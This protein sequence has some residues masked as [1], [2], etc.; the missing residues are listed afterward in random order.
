[1]LVASCAPGSTVPETRPADEVA[2]V[3]PI[4]GHLVRLEL[5]RNTTIRAATHREYELASTG[6]ISERASTAEVDCYY[7]GRPYRLDD[8]PSAA[9]DVVALSLC[10]GQIR[11][12]VMLDRTPWAIEPASAPAEVLVSRL[13]QPTSEATRATVTVEAIEPGFG[14][15][16]QGLVTPTKFLELVLYSDQQR[17]Q[18]LGSAVAT[19]AI[20]VANIADALYRNG[21]LTPAIG[22]V[23][24]AQIMFSRGNPFVV[25]D[26][27]STRVSNFRTWRTSRNDLPTGDAHFM[28]NGLGFTASASLG[29]AYTGGACNALTNFGFALTTTTT[30][31]ALEGTA[32][33]HELGHSLGMQ[34][35]GAG[36]ACATSGFIMSAGANSS[37]PY[38]HW[39]TCSQS[40]LTSFLAAQTCLDNS[41]TAGSVD[42]CG[43]GVVSGAEQ[44]DCG[45]DSCATVDPCCD[46][47]TCRYGDTDADGTPDCSDGCPSDPAKTAAGACGCGVAD[48]DADGDGTANCHDSCP[49]DPSKTSDADTDHDG[50]ANCVDGCPMDPAKRA[51]GTCGCGVADADADADG[52]ADCLDGC[53]NDASKTAPGTCGCGVS[54]CGDDDEDSDDEGSND[55]SGSGDG[56]GDPGSGGCASTGGGELGIA[57]LLVVVLRRRM[58]ALPRRRSVGPR[59][60]RWSPLIVLLVMIAVLATACGPSG[61]SQSGNCSNGDCSD[62][63]D[64]ST[65]GP[66]AN[67]PDVTFIGMPTTPSISLVLDRGSSMFSNNLGTVTRYAA[68]RDVF[69][70]TGGVVTQMDAEAYFGASVYTCSDGSA[71]SQLSMI[72][73]PRALSN[74]SAIGSALAT[75]NATT[76]F[77]SPTHAALDATVASFAAS[78]P[79]DAS[80]PAIILATDGQPTSCGT[81]PGANGGPDA[82][83]NAAAA[84]YAAG[85]PVYVVAITSTP[86]PLFQELANVGQGRPRYATG[87]ESIPYYS[88][89]DPQ[90]LLDTVRTMMSG[91][92]SCDQMLSADIDASQAMS[93]TVVYNQKTLTYGVDWLLVNGNTI[94]LLGDTCNTLRVTPNSYVAATFPCGAIL[95]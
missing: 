59:V 48:T 15:V 8:S 55:G 58:C 82:A 47:T 29:A 68:M 94:R 20:A 90:Y 52:T 23:V 32:T 3:L 65:N 14:V 22:L 50:A 49:Q 18:T 51:A 30:S 57:L 1:M 40:Y 61:S 25:A 95:L 10:G 69:V 7:R 11:G 36:N 73:T 21:E 38:T 54:S 33:A 92:I 16:R 93:G 70:G 84:A 34:H 78:P 24:T 60:M 79:P 31:S 86:S 19:D 45:V 88:A 87:A 6:E 63:G 27:P 72:N 71:S 13:D 80:S 44:C 12:L 46:P 17:V 35:D 4:D 67:C 75:G 2:I 5:E 83:V 53:A 43:D 42:R 26:S 89:T 66:D 39:S 9:S 77:N 56:N 81:G 62:E 74:A 85:V 76:S 41:A 91:I 64:A 37:S 28:L